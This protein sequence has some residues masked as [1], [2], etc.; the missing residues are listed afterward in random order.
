MTPEQV[1]QFVGESLDLNWEWTRI[2]IL[3]GEPTIHPRFREMIE[4]LMEYRRHH[5]NVL[6]RVISNG[7]GK[8]AEH[9]GW[10]RDSGVVVNIEGKRRDVTPSWFR[11]MRHAPIDDDPQCTHKPPCS[12]YG[13]GEGGC[14]IGL[15]R[16]GYFLCGAGAAIARVLGLDIGVMRLEDLTHEAMLKQAD[17]ICHLCGHWNPTD[18]TLRANMLR[19]TGNVMGPFWAEQL[20]DWQPKPMSIY[21]EGWE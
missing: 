7:N 19:K 3:G 10:L 6:L 20:R 9:H 11:N 4:P 5:P 8:L 1:K 2:H 12:I 16:H 13:Q 15:T 18:G 17:E 21:G 14:G